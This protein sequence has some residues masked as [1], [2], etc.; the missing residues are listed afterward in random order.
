MVNSGRLHVCMIIF[1]LFAIVDLGRSDLLCLPGGMFV[2]LDAEF[3]SQFPYCGTDGCI[4]GGMGSAYGCLCGVINLLFLF[5]A[6]NF[7]CYIHTADCDESL[8]IATITGKPDL[9]ESHSRLEDSRDQLVILLQYTLI[10][11]F[12]SPVRVLVVVPLLGLQSQVCW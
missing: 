2:L 1:S 8:Y 9:L 7:S 3:S 10:P 11:S 5:P 12:S 4:C 6:S